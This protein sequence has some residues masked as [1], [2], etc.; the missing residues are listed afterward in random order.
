[1]P[2]PHPW[3]IAV[4]FTILAP[5]IIAMGLLFASAM[6]GQPIAGIVY[7]FG[8][9]FIYAVL[10]PMFSS[11]MK[12]RVPAGYKPA[13]C[14]IFTIHPMV[15]TLYSA[16]A[17]Y[18]MIY[19]YTFFYVMFPS[20]LEH[21]TLGPVELIFVSFMCILI[22]LTL[23]VRTCVLHCLPQDLVN[24]S[25]SVASGSIIGLAWGIILSLV[26][27]SISK[28]A[29]WSFSA[30]QCESNKMSCTRPTD[31]DYV[32]TVTKDGKNLGTL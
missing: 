21:K 31:Q 16:P 26:V 6:S 13:L 11:M 8:L 4:F 22:V 17:Y 7:V 15:N 27:T 3:N 2:S 30:V 24:F 20:F 9:L 28:N 32:C 1:M 23:V 25:I 18:I 19:V 14:N 12:M 5:P 29:A 10:W